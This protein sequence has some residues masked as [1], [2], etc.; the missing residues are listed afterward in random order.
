MN[1]T[2]IGTIGDGPEPETALTAVGAAGAL[3]LGSVMVRNAWSG[4][5][6]WSLLDTRIWQFVQLCRP[7]PGSA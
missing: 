7:L 5:A 4:V 1:E 3:G 2:F 6:A